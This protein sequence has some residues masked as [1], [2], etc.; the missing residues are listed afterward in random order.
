MDTNS[1][2][3]ALLRRNYLF[4]GLPPEDLDEDN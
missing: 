1:N 2:E 3:S 4:A